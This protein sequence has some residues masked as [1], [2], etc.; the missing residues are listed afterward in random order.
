M[1][2]A[3]RKEEPQLALYPQPCK[4]LA[5]GCPLWAEGLLEA[6]Q[7]MVSLTSDPDDMLSPAVKTRDITLSLVLEMRPQELEQ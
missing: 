4:P 3:A 7:P 1:V 5:A 2:Y 6:A